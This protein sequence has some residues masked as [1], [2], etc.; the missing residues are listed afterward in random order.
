[1]Q[2]RGSIRDRQLSAELPVAAGWQWKR[3]EVRKMY[4]KDWWRRRR[5]IDS[6]SSRKHFFGSSCSF[7]FVP[8]L[9]VNVSGV[10]SSL[11]RLP[12]Q[13]IFFSHIQTVSR[14]IFWSLEFKPHMV[15]GLKCDPDF[16]RYVSV[17][18][19]MWLTVRKLNVVVETGVTEVHQSGWAEFR[20]LWAE[21]YGSQ[22]R[23]QLIRGAKLK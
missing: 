18:F 19:L 7:T 20:L 3:R 8:K 6:L 5:D 17:R 21:W 9:L 23:E 12:A 1:M 10:S 22:Y 15:R 2:E 14:L 16:Y 13:I 4:V 11:F